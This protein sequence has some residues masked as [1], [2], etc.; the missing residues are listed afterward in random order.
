MGGMAKRRMC[1]DSLGRTSA[2]NVRLVGWGSSLLDEAGLPSHSSVDATAL[3]A[4][5]TEVATPAW[6]G[7][8]QAEVYQYHPTWA[9]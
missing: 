1:E 6:N 5:K 8:S 9:G 3:R 7:R 2:A 4:W